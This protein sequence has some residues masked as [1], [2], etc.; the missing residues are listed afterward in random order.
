VACLSVQVVAYQWAPEE[1]YPQVLEAVSMLVLEAACMR[2]R[3]RSR[4]AAIGL[5]EPCLLST[6]SEAE[7]SKSPK[8][9]GGHG[10]CNR[11]LAAEAAT[12]LPIRAEESQGVREP[13]RIRPSPETSPRARSIPWPARFQ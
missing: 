10:D 8:S 9:L 1:A 4:T 11:L 12:G 5:R 2:D 3:A 7:S 6:S 13:C